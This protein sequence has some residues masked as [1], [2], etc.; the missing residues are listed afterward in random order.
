MNISVNGQSRVPPGFRFHPTEEEL[1]QY[2]L[3]KKVANEKIDLDVVFEIDLNR[4][5]PWDIQEKC[6]IGTTPQNDWYFF[7]HKDKKY[8]TGTR[9]NRA[10]VAGFWKATGR[11]K[12]IYGN[13]RRIGMRKTLV[14]YKGRAPHGQKSDWIMHEY[15]LDGSSNSNND[16]QVSSHVMNGEFAQEEGWV[17][18]KI[19]KKKN[20]IVKTLDTSMNTTNMTMKLHSNII[21]SPSHNNNNDQGA[22]E[23][24][25]QSLG[26]NNNN[27]K[28]LLQ[29]KNII[30]KSTFHQLDK[31]MKLPSLES[32]SNDFYYQPMN[33][34]RNDVV[35]IANDSEIGIND[36]AT[37]DRFVATHL[38]GH[39]HTMDTMA[40]IFTSSSTTVDLGDHDAIQLSPLRS[41]SSTSS[42][43]KIYQQQDNN[44]LDNY[45]NSEI[46]LWSFT[47][48][49]LSIDPLCHVS[50]AGL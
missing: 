3:R 30:T 33:P 18:C 34:S 25:F 45:G 49:S 11:D 22:L 9:T 10:T 42:G 5:E 14:F 2:Y 50:D 28:L 15:R 29:N 32:P 44:T 43:N 48:A 1:L 40:S 27:D 8:P 4:L 6:R 21:D 20:H 39:H 12:V 19:F 17:I 35:S 23:Q 26:S 47:R 16:T 38:N 31:F 37:L 24:I 41:S 13:C 7:S 46:D 36:W